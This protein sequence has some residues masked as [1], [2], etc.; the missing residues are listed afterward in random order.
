MMLQRRDQG[1]LPG[2]ASLKIIRSFSRQRRVESMS[3]RKTP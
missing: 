1:K 3:R 2:E